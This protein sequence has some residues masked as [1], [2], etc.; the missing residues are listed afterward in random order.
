MTALVGFNAAVGAVEQIHES[1]TAL[2][3][4]DA[5]GPGEDG[6]RPLGLLFGAPRT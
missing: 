4:P 3:P 5:A 2:T 1:V 6:R